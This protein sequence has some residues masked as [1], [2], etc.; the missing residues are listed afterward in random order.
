[1][2][3]LEEDVP[4]KPFMKIKQLENDINQLEGEVSRLI[5][6]ICDLT[7][8][9]VEKDETIKDLHAWSKKLEEDQVKKDKIIAE[10]HGVLVAATPMESGFSK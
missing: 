3:E 10:M 4:G 1:M 6:R 2:K 8:E 7:K 5:D 9:L